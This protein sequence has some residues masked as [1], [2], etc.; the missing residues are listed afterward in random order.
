[1]FGLF[2]KSTDSEPSSARVMRPIYFHN[3]LSGTLEEFTPLRKGEVKMYQCGP[4]VYDYSH[5]GNLKAYLLADLL[6]R[7]FVYNGY[8]VKQVINV[9]DFGHLASDADAGEDKM[10]KGLK[11]EGM[12]PTMDNMLKLGTKYMEAF[13]EDLKLFNVD[14]KKIQFT[15]A[16]DYIKE[17]IMVNKTLEGKGVAY[18]TSDGLYFDTSKY[19]DYGKLGNIDLEGLQ[20]GVRVE[21]KEKKNPTDFA[22][23]KKDPKLGWNS[24]WGKGFP[25][26]HI[27]CTGMIFATLGT[28]IDVHT[29]G[30]DLIPTHHNN[31]IA[32]AEAAT[33]KHF[34]GYWLHNA[35][36]TLESRRIGKSEGNAIRLVQLADRG[37]TPFDYRYWLLTGHYRTPMNFTWQAL[38]GAQQA[39]TRLH[40]IF[41]EDLGRKNGSVHPEYQKRFHEAINDDLDTPKA[42]A[43]LWELAK[44]DSVSKE[45]KRATFLDFDRV[46]GIGFREGVKKLTEMLSVR[47]VSLKD[48]PQEVQELVEEREKARKDRNWG[49]ADMLREKIKEHGYTVE[50]TDKGSRLTKLD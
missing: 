36:I 17:Q 32:Q 23:W 14:T 44:D 2:N 34:V 37:Y 12:E 24:P 21:M 13:I 8:R 47:V 16:S 5:I 9:T 29:G 38:D 18:E 46:L 10:T 6:R 11:R 31:E 42:I 15:R 40:R 30:I 27:E 4:T 7:M 26:W 25:G 43:I 20:E 33:G 39:L 28:Q 45:D 1:M 49:E 41:V 50:D 35:F 19:P 3:T 48:L 22:L